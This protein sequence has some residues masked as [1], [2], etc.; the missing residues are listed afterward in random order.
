MACQ[1][2]GQL[3]ARSD[4]KPR[5]E[6]SSSS[7]DLWSETDLTELNHL[8]KN[9]KPTCDVENENNVDYPRSYFSN[10]SSSCMFPVK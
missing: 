10:S 5:Y 4:F 6:K 2:T 9:K 8:E 7:V 1:S 3:H